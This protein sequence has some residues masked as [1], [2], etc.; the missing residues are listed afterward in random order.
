M[1]LLWLLAGFWASAL[2]GNAHA[3]VNKWDFSHYYLSAAALRSGQNPYNTDLAPMG[4]AL[5]LQ[6]DEINR[7]TYPPT[8]VLCFEPLTLMRPVSAYWTWFGLNVLALALAFALLLQNGSLGFARAMTFV[9]LAILYPPLMEHFKYAQSQIAVLLC[10]VLMMRSLRQGDQIL[11]GLLL[12]FATMLRVFPIVM[13][14]YL[15][16]ERKWLA[17]RWMTIGIAVIGV[18]TLAF[19]GWTASLSFLRLFGFLTS[20]H[21]YEPTGNISAGATISRIFWYT[22]GTSLSPGLDLL[23]RAAGIIAEFAL[24]VITTRVAR[25]HAQIEEGLDSQV[26]SLWVVATILLAPTAWFHYLVLLFI[27]YALIASAAYA[28]RASRRTI[29]MAVASYAII[30]MDMMVF[31]AIDPHS[32]SWLAILLRERAIISLGMAYVA[33]YWFV[34]DGAA[35]LNVTREVAR[36]G[37]EA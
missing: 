7:A 8:F 16:V 2:F 31:P 5:G 4:A 13:V 22:L 25:S 10:L 11:A 34:S 35:N 21:W 30:W 20:K 33:A 12:A 29:R 28:G 15:L 6:V 9:A 36:Q 27:P 23:R 26:F 17:L 24:L 19:V 18:V 1:T 37:I 32:T 14:G 3:R